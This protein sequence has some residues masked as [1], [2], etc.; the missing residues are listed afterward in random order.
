MLGEGAGNY[1]H[2]QRGEDERMM[3]EGVQPW[4]EQRHGCERKK[5]PESWEVL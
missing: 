3:A 1:Q 4:Q 5:I 2:V